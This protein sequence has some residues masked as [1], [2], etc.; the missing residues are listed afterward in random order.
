MN[1]KN[2]VITVKEEPL[3]CTGTAEN[4]PQGQ[5]S[6]SQEGRIYLKGKRTKLGMLSMLPCFWEAILR[7][8]FL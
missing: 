3:L 6:K 2:E 5:E 1:P 7:S 4:V 8:D